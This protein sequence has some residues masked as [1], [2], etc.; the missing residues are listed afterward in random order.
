MTSTPW[1]T[2]ASESVFSIYSACD[3]PML[4]PS[5]FT[6]QH[7]QRRNMKPCGRCSDMQKKCEVAPPFSSK[8]CK[9]CTKAHIPVCPP[10]K[11]RRSRRRIQN[12]GKTATGA[13]NAN[14]DSSRQP[15]ALLADGSS[16]MIHR[17]IPSA[18]DEIL[19]PAVGLD[20]IAAPPVQIEHSTLTVAEGGHLDPVFPAPLNENEYALLQSMLL[21]LAYGGSHTEF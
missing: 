12:G 5:A 11:G 19:A 2:A 4:F 9:E 10:Y 6:V 14:D 18:V 20:L 16:Q 7:M 21:G 1:E 3:N 15:Q 13:S 8:R 17:Q